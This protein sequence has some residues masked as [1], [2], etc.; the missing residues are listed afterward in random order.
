MLQASLLDLTPDSPPTA[1]LAGV[2]PSIRAAMARV[3]REYPEGRKSLPDA[4][5][6]VAQRENVPLT[7]KGGKTV[8]LEQLHKWL[9]PSEREHEPGLRAILCY[10]LATQDFSPLEP[11]W[12]ACGLAVIPA[13]KLWYLAYGEACDAEKKARKARCK[14]EA[15]L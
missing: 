14:L 7:P 6:E 8:T 12:K 5:S 13:D 9:Q 10:C 11:I 2:M 1:G 4:I 15:R 3:A